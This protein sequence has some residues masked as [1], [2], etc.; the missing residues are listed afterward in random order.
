MKRKIAVYAGPGRQDRIPKIGKGKKG[1]GLE[2]KWY[3]TCVANARP[4]LLSTTN[5]KKKKKKK[6]E[7]KGR[8]DPTYPKGMW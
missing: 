4:H 2:L 1:L 7:K 5:K 6:K 3:S 8:T